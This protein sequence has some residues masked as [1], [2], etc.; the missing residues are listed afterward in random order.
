MAAR[1]LHF[2]WDDCYRVLVLRRAGYAVTEAQTLAELDCG[3]QRDGPVDAVVLSEDGWPV[4]EQAVEIVRRQSVAPLILF[5]RSH[6]DIDEGRF[7]QVYPWFVS[8]AEW[9]KRT[10]DLI[11][12]SRGLRERSASLRLQS[13]AVRR[14]TQRQRTRLQAELARS[15][16][17]WEP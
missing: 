4:I 1:V 14:E 6:D 15:K 17:K 3:L 9:L 5:R 10:A 7:D 8:P 11:A 2:G 12:R 16:P 13:Q